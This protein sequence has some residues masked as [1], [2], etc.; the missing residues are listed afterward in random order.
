M[1]EDILVRKR[2]KHHGTGFANLS[3]RRHRPA[4]ARM[5]KLN[6][7]KKMIVS[8]KKPLFRI[9]MTFLQ[10]VEKIV[11]F[12]CGFLIMTT[13]LFTYMP[14]WS[15]KLIVAEFTSVTSI[16]DDVTPRTDLDESILED[17]MDITIEEAFAQDLEEDQFVRAGQ[18]LFKVTKK[19]PKW[20]W[21]DWLIPTIVAVLAMINGNALAYQFSRC[22]KTNLTILITLC[23]VLFT[24]LGLFAPR[25]ALNLK[26]DTQLKFGRYPPTREWSWHDILGLTF[27]ATFLYI[28]QIAFPFYNAAKWYA[29]NNPNGCKAENETLR[30]QQVSP[31]DDEVGALKKLIQV[32]VNE[33]NAT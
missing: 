27:A 4:A 14:K 33:I 15:R 5:M 25:L 26:P 17:G 19:P 7:Q 18:K 21:Y 24:V 30:V 23:G 16:P 28:S 31:C 11:A 20:Q 1:G 6:R 3:R 13:I 2:K 10:V 8:K 32:F 22:S 12:I 29:K 9:A